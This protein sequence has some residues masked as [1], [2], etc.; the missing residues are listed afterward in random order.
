M[1]ANRSDRRFPNLLGVQGPRGR[2]NAIG[3]NVRIS[4]MARSARRFIER[5][6][7]CPQPEVRTIRAA[8]LRTGL[9][10][11]MH[12]RNQATSWVLGQ[13]RASVKV[14]KLCQP[15]TLLFETREEAFDET[16]LLERMR[17]NEPVGAT[18]SRGRWLESSGSGR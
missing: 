8:A 4:I 15:D 17:R 12:P 5:P 6:N 16:I 10:P 13:V 9:G 3:E 1:M 18:D 14:P 11:Y 2:C 7:T